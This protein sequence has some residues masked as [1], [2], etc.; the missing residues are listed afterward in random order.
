MFFLSNFER[1]PLK[2]TEPV[3]EEDLVNLNINE[4]K[5]GNYVRRAASE[6]VPKK[7]TKKKTIENHSGS[8][9]SKRYQFKFNQGR[10]SFF[11][12]LYV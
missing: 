2:K 3:E 6:H 12:I 11:F 1:P 4:V 7:I 10:F 8:T 5:M 9:N